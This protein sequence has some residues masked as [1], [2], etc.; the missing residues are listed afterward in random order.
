MAEALFRRAIK[1][2][3]ALQ[4]VEVDSAGVGAIEG[5][6]ATEAAVAVMQA[7]DIDLS[8]HRAKPV[9]FGAEY[10]LVLA[11]DGHTRVVLERRRPDFSLFTLGSYA[12]TGED[13]QDPYGGSDA[14]FRRC[15][16]Q[17]GRLVAAAADRLEAERRA[18][19]QDQ[20]C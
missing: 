19:P 17:I 5:G 18:S 10:D 1:D 11:L 20:P 13:V 4:D 14:T 8:G 6:S 12:G 2:R 16:E 7:F 15:A 3:P 9:P